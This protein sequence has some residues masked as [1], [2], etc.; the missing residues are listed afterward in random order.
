MFGVVVVDCDIEFLVIEGVVV[1][2]GDFGC[3]FVVL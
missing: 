2:V 3:D 1:D